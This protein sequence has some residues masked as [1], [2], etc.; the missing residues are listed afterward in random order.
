MFNPCSVG[1]LRL[2][3][4][5]PRC[6]FCPWR[7]YFETYFDFNSFSFLF[8]SLPDK[9]YG[10]NLINQCRWLADFLS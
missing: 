7:N 10:G 6:T 4:R 1:D 5:L 2:F 3:S 8:F 9:L